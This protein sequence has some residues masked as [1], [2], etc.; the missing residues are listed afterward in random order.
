MRR[1]AESGGSWNHH[2]GIAAEVRPGEVVLKFC[3]RVGRGMPRYQTR[4]RRQL[5]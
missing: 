4:E 1:L 5:R 3:S 2:S